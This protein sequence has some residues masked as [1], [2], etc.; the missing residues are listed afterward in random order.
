MLILSSP[1]LLRSRFRAPHHRGSL[2]V[3]PGYTASD[4]AT[5]LLR[6]YLTW[7]GYR[8]EGW[9]LGRNHGRVEKLLPQL[10]LRLVSI[11]Q[12]DGCPPML[13][14][15]SLGGYLARQLARDNPTQVA[16]IITLGTPVVGGPK[17]TIVNRHYRRWGYPIEQIEQELAEQNRTPMPV[18]V[19][20]FYS[21]YDGIVHWRA[22]LDPQASTHQQ[23]VICTHVGMMVSP[24]L[25]RQL[26]K[27]LYKLTQN[28]SADS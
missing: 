18:P 2:L 1:W 12:R 27:E 10:Q 3:I 22:C 13:V 23:A 14:G 20:A 11:N 25:F 19:S 16:G 9:Q 15:W 17:Y 24:T 28:V 7:L 21:L 5:W 8:V 6:K 26:A 4:K